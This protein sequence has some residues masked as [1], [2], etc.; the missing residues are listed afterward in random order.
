VLA[1]LDR[2]FGNNLVIGA[3]FGY[4]RTDSKYMND[5]GTLSADNTT[6]MLYTTYLPTSSTYLGAY[7]GG[8][9]G[10]QDATRNI[11]A[12]LITGVATSTTKPTQAMA[13]A[14]GGYNYYSGSFSA[15]ATAAMDYVRNHTDSITESGNTSLEFFYPEQNTYSLTSTLGGRASYRSPFTWGAVTPS[16][17]A[18]YIH[19]FRDNARTISPSLVSNPAT[20]FAFR[21]DDP[22]R[23]YY[24]GGASV[25]VEAGRGTQFFIDYEQRWGHKFIDT[26]AASLGMILEF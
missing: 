21:T 14:S 12:G 24:V 10:K 2:R 22:D 6:A 16:I 20:V 23:N 11:S 15:S 19:E 25:T 13:G 26:W 18:S 4:S 3:S 9:Q 8:G 5:G 7:L 1:G 17:R